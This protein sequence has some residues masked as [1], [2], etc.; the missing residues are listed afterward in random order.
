MS[1]KEQNSKIVAD[2]FRQG[3]K[4]DPSLLGVEVEHFVVYADTLHGVPYQS[5]D[6]RLGVLDVLEYLAQFYRRKSYGADGDLIGLASKKGTVTLEPASQLEISIAP[7]RTVAEVK[8]VYEE[9]RAQVDPFLEEHGA[10]L[11]A[12]GYHPHNKALELPLIP[13]RRYHFM[14]DFFRS[15]GLNGE[16]MMRASASTQVS[17]D[18]TDE[19]DAVRKM[20]VAQALAP[21]LS[22]LADNTRVFEG[23]PTDKPLEHLNLWRNVA[24]FH[25][26]SVPGL[27]NEGWGFADYAS[28]LLGVEPIFITR[29]AAADPDGES[30]RPFFDVPAFEAY[31]DAPMT[32]AD[33]EHLISMVW[34]DVRLK[35]FVEIR[36]ADSL[37]EDKIL[38]Y[39]ALVKGI[40]YNE[41]SLK[42][43]EDAF[44]VVDGVWPLD[45]SSTDEALALIREQGDSAVIYGKTLSDWKRFA[46]ETAQ[47]ALSPEEATYLKALQA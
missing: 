19:A 37:P 42:A 12:A 36:P 24:K 17:V 18:F 47:A 23:E 41:A 35:R 30:M 22:A 21:V 9:F 32:E 15:I 38:G 34:P 2:Y 7:Y 20:R 16:R 27:F 46:L 8:A 33:V 4:E 13:K 26:G 3:A 25:C 6:G 10:K 29:P 39:T 40:F 1:Y 28:W 11:V 43:M 5:E 14:D 45:D 31:G 44:G